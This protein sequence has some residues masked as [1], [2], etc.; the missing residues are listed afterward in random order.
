MLH[1][2]A[3]DYLHSHYLAIKITILILDI[4]EFI[5]FLL[6]KAFY[7]KIAGFGISFNLVILFILIKLF[8]SNAKILD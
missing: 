3:I 4:P 5:I 6:N 1:K 2:F 8:L 7:K